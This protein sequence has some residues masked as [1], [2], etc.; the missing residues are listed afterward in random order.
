MERIRSIVGNNLRIIRK[1][2]Q[3]TLQELSDITGVS[4]SMLGEIERSVTNPT[5]TVLWKIVGGLKIPFTMLIQEEKPTVT[6]VREK[7]TKSFI[8]KDEFKISSIFE[9]DPEK[10]F[11]IYHI[12]FSPGSKHESKGHNKGVEEYTFVYEGE[13]VTEVDGEKFRLN[14]GDSIRFEA[15]NTHAYIN[16]GHKDAK[17]YSIIFY[18][19]GN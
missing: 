12:Q 9:F 11:E 2:K 18:G 8:E 3:L 7:D 10:K 15:E 19:S 6:M 1:E 5:I 13:L 4:K 17:A 14:A 16:E